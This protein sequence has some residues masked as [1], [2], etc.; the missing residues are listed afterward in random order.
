MSGAGSAGSGLGRHALTTVNGDFDELLRRALHAEADSIEPAAGGL[1][2]IRHRI[3]APWLVRQ[4]SLM[5]TDCVD[6]VRLIGIRLEPGLTSTWGA[7]AGRAGSWR[8]SCARLCSQVS[9][10]ARIWALIGPSR[11]SATHRGSPQRGNLAWLRPALAVA[12]A[13]FIVVAGVYG[14]FQA[15]DNLV[16][17]L[18]P[19]SNAPAS[20]GPGGGSVAATGAHP[21]G[22]VRRGPSSSPPS[23]GA[24][25]RQA[26]AK[27]QLHTFIAAGGHPD[28]D[29]VR[30][31]H[32]DGLA[33]HVAEPGPLRQ[34]QPD[35]DWHG[36]QHAADQ[37]HGE[38]PEPAARP[39]IQPPAAGSPAPEVAKPV[40]HRLDHG[41]TGLP[42][43]TGRRG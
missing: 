14:L 33:E 13:V 18:F 15:R 27:S 17:E 1:E 41:A 9:I 16:L 30:Q 38:Q 36:D 37:R 10:L 21:A 2:R 35:A 6:L 32:T 24:P 8:A 11:H 7:I 12:A 23:S 34:H 26:V 31:R 42:K 4:M 25:D 5:L 29:G 40:P 20:P 3:S 39:A 28:S 43:T 19:G 22:A